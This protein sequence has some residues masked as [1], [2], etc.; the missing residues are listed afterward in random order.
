MR[1][2]YTTTALL[3]FA[4]S[5]FLTDVVQGQNSS[6]IDESLF[7]RVSVSLD[8]SRVI[9]QLGDLG[10]AVDHVHIHD[11]TMHLEIS[12]FE[13][14]L[15]EQAGIDY[16]IHVEDMAAYYE[17]KLVND[18]VFQSGTIKQAGV[19]DNFTLGSMGGHLTLDEVNEQLD[20]M[21]DL[22]PDLITEKFSIGESFEGRDIWT[23]WIR[24]EREDG[25]Q[26][27]QAYYNSLIHAR[28]PM[29]MMNLVYYMWW[30]LENYDEDPLATFLIDERDMAFTLV[31]NPDGYEYNRSNSPNGGGMH[32]KNRRPVGS[33]NQGVDLNRNFGPFYFWDH[34]NGG[35]S[36]SPDSD[37]FRGGL[38]FSE[39][40][41]QAMRDFVL[42]ND[43]RTVFN[44][45]NFSN[46]LIYPYGALQRET[47][48][49]HIFTA[50]AVD[51]TAENEYE[52]GTDIETVGYNTRGAAD[53]WFYGS[54]SGNPDGRVNAITFT[55]EVG[56]VS[57]GTGGVWGAFWARAERIVPLSQDNLLPNQLLA[58]Y[59]GPELRDAEGDFFTEAFKPELNGTEAEIG[60]ETPL[61]F[62]FE[63]LYNYG[64]TSAEVHLHAEISSEYAMLEQETLVFE[65]DKDQ[66]F[67]G[68]AEAFFLEVDSFAEPGIEIPL[69]LTLSV[70]AMRDSYSWEYTLTTTGVPVS[71]EPDREIPARIALE[72]NYPNPF[73]PETIIQFSLPETADISLDVYDTM[74]RRVQTLVNEQRSAGEHAVRF[75]GSGLTSGVYMY[76]LQAGNEVHIKKMTLIK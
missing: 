2:I 41:T 24:S 71:T 10:V 45:H 20:L 55:P 43:F 67:S 32:R 48:D 60:D 53:D 34:P 16:S 29:S 68:P 47:Q 61:V 30:L 35:S 6:D 13:V 38:P 31:L 74:G 27:P 21:H 3:V 4:F 65:I 59:A 17:Q 54:E 69:T 39:P 26:K 72:Q 19:P 73:N 25:V 52:Y 23:V 28:E 14:N 64:R 62:S 46:L 40:E 70:P 1:H 11:K 15:M 5:L 63:T 8:D 37:T 22:Y 57:D 7:Y 42:E 51:M 76:R 18:P 44:Y 66:L 50:Y 12:G 33:F 49:A 36:L 56:G 75:D 9:Q 58:L